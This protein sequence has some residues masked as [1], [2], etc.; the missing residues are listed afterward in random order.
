MKFPKTHNTKDGFTLVEMLVVA[1][2]VILA[3]GAF[4]TTIISMTGEVIASRASNALSYNVQDALNRI[5]Q[6]VKLSSEFLAQ[7]NILFQGSNTNQGYNDDTT[8]F[9]NVAGASGTSIIINIAA[10]TKDPFSTSSSYVFLKNTPN[11]CAT[12]QSNTIFTYN[13]VYFIKDSTLWRRTLMSENYADTANTVCSTPWQRP[14][15]SPTYME[16]QTAPV[17]CKTSDVKLVSGVKPADFF[18]QYFNSASATSVNEP[19]SNSSTSTSDRATAMQS[20]TTVSVAIHA[21]Q[22]AGGRDIERSAV[23]R[24][25][26]L[27]N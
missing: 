2:I 19:A 16:S 26:R 6:D 1:P 10:T 11:P 25:S 18:V 14:S 24:A 8:N 7:N 27:S 22:I 13:V 17:F 21:E 4:L 15:C 20:V 3:I 5:E 12:A 23:L 9:T